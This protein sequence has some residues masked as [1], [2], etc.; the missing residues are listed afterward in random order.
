MKC[1]YIHI[2]MLF[3]VCP[4]PAP[5]CPDGRS[6][7]CT[8]NAVTGFPAYNCLN[9]VGPVGYP[10]PSTGDVIPYSSAVL[11]NGPN[12]INSTGSR[13]LAG[14][15]LLEL[16]RPQDIYQP[17]FGT[18]SPTQGYSGISGSLPYT[19]GPCNTLSKP[20]CLLK[21]L[22]CVGC[23]LQPFLLAA[24]AGPF[25][26]PCQFGY[27]CSPSIQLRS[28]LGTPPSPG[29]AGYSQPTTSS[30]YPEALSSPPSGVMPEIASPNQYYTPY[31]SHGLSGRNDMTRNSY[32][33]GLNPPSQMKGTSVF[34]GYQVPTYKGTVD[35]YQPPTIETQWKAIQSPVAGQSFT[36][37]QIWPYNFQNY[38]SAGNSPLP[39]KQPIISPSNTYYPQ[40]QSSELNQPPFLGGLNAA[41]NQQ[42][43]P[44][45]QPM[46]GSLFPDGESR[47]PERQLQLGSL[48]NHGYHPLPPY[49]GPKSPFDNFPLSQ[50]PAAIENPL[51]PLSTQIAR[52]PSYQLQKHMAPLMPGSLG[53]SV[54]SSLQTGFQVQEVQSL[55]QPNF[56]TNHQRSLPL[57][58]LQS[59]LHTQNPYSISSNYQQLPY[60]Q[61]QP[62]PLNYTLEKRPSRKLPLFQ[63]DGPSRNPPIL[64][65][66][67]TSGLSLLE[68]Q[69]PHPK[70]HKSLNTDDRLPI[71]PR[72]TAKKTSLHKQTPDTSSYW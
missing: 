1:K 35:G 28:E 48:D 46:G 67:L 13:I 53:Q 42:I 21:A 32:G 6:A 8:R 68:P 18:G 56:H 24:I 50:K 16:A 14:R 62:A 9:P 45:G 27:S 15:S 4:L 20:P 64:P 59:R 51:S 3:S 34:P 25:C 60:F 72:K 52:T 29:Q 65:P 31:I 7:V 22:G 49:A 44:I 39:V 30:Q 36:N 12:V 17:P 54:Q 43:Y 57:I 63:P 33:F 41:V 10:W 19:N 71:I 5:I 2:F 37:H 40:I 26:Q 55:V 23:C 70:E 69:L 11:S 58:A 66:F 47:Q 61:D 38:I